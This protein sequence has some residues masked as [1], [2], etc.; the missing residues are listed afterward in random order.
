MLAGLACLHLAALNRQH[1][2]I[3]ELAEK[4]ADLNIQVSLGIMTTLSVLFYSDSCNHLGGG[5]R[6]L[7][8]VIC[9]L[10]LTSP[11]TDLEDQAQSR[12]AEMF[13]IFIF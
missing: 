8:G 12:F 7:P 1:Q 10:T 2:I 13:F 5:Y 6:E 3:Y 4:G 9:L 11:N